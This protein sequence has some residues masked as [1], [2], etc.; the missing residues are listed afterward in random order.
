MNKY[1]IFSHFEKWDVVAQKYVFFGD[2]GLQFVNK[3]STFS[4]DWLA[5]GVKFLI[6]CLVCSVL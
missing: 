2:A 4:A 1:I 5:I 6:R 3:I